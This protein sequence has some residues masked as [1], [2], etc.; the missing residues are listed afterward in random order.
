MQNR[1]RWVACQID[2]LED[3]LDYPTLRS[4]LNSLPETLDETYARMIK[5]IPAGHKQNA[6]R[7]LQFL[8][9]S[10]RPLRI[11]EVVDAI[12]VDTERI[13]HFL[14]KNRMP[15]RAEITRYC[16]SLVVM[17]SPKGHTI[18]NDEGL[19]E[20]QLAH[21]SVKEYLTSNRLDDGIRFFFQEAAARASMTRV[22]LAYLLHFDQV[23]P[24]QQVRKD[25]PFAQYCARYWISHAQ[26]AGCESSELLDLVER[27]FCYETSSYRFCYYLY[28]P[29]EPWHNE[30][31]NSSGKPAPALYYAA[32]GGLEEVVKLL[33]SKKADVNAQGGYYSTALQAA[34]YGGHEAIVKLLLNKNAN[35]NA[36]G[37]Y[38]GNALQAASEAGH[39]A[40]VKLLL[41][42]NADVNAQGGEYGNA[43][44]VASHE[45]YEAIVKLLLDKNADVNAQGGEY[46][47][48]LQAAS[49][50]GHE[51][52]VK[53]LLNKN[54]DV[55]AQGGEY[56]NA[57]QAASYGGHEAIVK[58]LLNKNANVNA[59]G[60]VYGNALQAASVQG[61]KA[62]VKLLLD[63]NADV[64]AQGG[65]YGNALQAASYRGYKA[66]V[67]LLLDAGAIAS[68]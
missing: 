53:L 11:K 41:D 3:C 10:E 51:A 65:V 54:A 63:K 42:K 26:A 32:F 38:Y 28:R 17:V 24:L 39:E 33:L 7:I 48:A 55:N 31:P 67:K 20:L 59:Q 15:E 40:I 27:L 35:V 68:P 14:T 62:I 45:G 30:P 29:D 25:F 8:T 18:E 47:N 6:L 52:I 21:F 16:S 9:F 12:A 1:F 56:G 36:Q 66:I 5:A 50:G 34:S 57:L 19:M 23:L 22:C 2:A 43:L 37:G 61:Y 58:L 60:G 4:A 46:G 13:P 44:Q 49:Y 64:N